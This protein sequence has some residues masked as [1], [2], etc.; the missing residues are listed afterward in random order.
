M[1]LVE[2]HTPEPSWSGCVRLP[3]DAD[4]HTQATDDEIGVAVADVR[5]KRMVGVV[6]V[7]VAV[8]TAYQRQAVDVHQDQLE[9]IRQA[10][11]VRLANAQAVLAG[12]S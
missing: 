10:I 6:E 12:R 3:D 9:L 5:C 11:Q 8:E 7:W 2:W 4:P 1:R